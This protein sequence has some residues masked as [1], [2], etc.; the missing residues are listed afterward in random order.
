[1]RRL[2]VGVRRQMKNRKQIFT[3]MFFLAGALGFSLWARYGLIE[4]SSVATLCNATSVPLRCTVRNYVIA[5]TALPLW[6]YVALAAGALA[7]FVRRLDVTVL[8]LVAGAIGL[9]L[10][11]GE[12]AAAGFLL[13]WITLARLTLRASPA[14]EQ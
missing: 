8:A 13:G 7:V 2:H 12:T 1:M 9:V 10:Y 11:A 6:G 14:M 4:S 3:C 5:G